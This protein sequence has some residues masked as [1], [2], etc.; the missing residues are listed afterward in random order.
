[1]FE[2]SD[3]ESDRFYK[4]YSDHNCEF[5]DK[6]TCSITFSFSP[7]GYNCKVKIACKCGEEIDITE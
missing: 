2:M 3:V 6:E 7:A 1:M 5:T 4:W